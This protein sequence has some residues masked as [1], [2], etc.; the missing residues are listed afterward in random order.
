MKKTASKKPCKLQLNRE[1]LTAL[2]GQ[3]LHGV[4]GG[5]TTPFASCR[6]CGLCATATQLC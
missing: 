5:L 1:T 3:D 4:N 6:T 2:E